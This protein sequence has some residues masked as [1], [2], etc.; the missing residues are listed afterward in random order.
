MPVLRREMAQIDP[1]LSLSNL[2]SME[3]Q[4]RASLFVERLVAI[5]CAAFSALATI[6]ASVGLYGAV[7]FSVARRTHEIGIRMALGAERRRIL[8]MV[9]T[10]V[11][12]MWLIGVG[13]GLPAAVGLARLIQS[14]LYGVGPADPVTLA[15]VALM[16]CMSLAAGFLPARRAATVDPMEA[17]HYQ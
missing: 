4:V 6:L 17:L 16:L 9:M 8:R 10:E 11:A 14:N 13:V 5:L 15:S 7:A 3:G 2:I 1:D 12:W